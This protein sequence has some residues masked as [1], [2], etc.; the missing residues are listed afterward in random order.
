MGRF[1]EGGEAAQERGRD[2]DKQLTGSP[3]SIEGAEPKTFKIPAP[4]TEAQADN[5]DNQVQKEGKPFQSPGCFQLWPMTVLPTTLASR[6]AGLVKEWELS[7]GL[8]VQSSWQRSLAFPW[9][10]LSYP[11][12]CGQQ[13][14]QEPCS[15][16]AAAAAA[17]FPTYHQTG[18]SCKKMNRL[19]AKT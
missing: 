2:Q 1:G 10:H 4:H 12:R 19:L 17:D 6:S 14:Q 9:G 5:L 18:K 3:H 11:V 7:H 15:F 16:Q 8:R 13:Q